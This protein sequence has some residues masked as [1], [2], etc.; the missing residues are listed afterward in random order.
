MNDPYDSP[1][2]RMQKAHEELLARVKAIEADKGK[3]C[4]TVIVDGVVVIT[5]AGKPKRFATSYNARQYGLNQIRRT[6]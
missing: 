4:W 2:G 3:L 1:I 5:K 6:R